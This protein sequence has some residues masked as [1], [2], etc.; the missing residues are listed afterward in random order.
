M[1][2]L[3]FKYQYWPP[4]NASL[5]DQQF[6]TNYLRHCKDSVASHPWIHV[7]HCASAKSTLTIKLRSS[8]GAL[9]LY[10]KTNTVYSVAS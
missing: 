3:K 10:H 2:F 7:K 6:H 4:N 9:P 5:P 1:I 8:C